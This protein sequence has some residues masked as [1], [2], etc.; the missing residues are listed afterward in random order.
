MPCLFACPPPKKKKKPTRHAASSAW[1]STS[2]T[3]LVH[4]RIAVDQCRADPSPNLSISLTVHPSISLTVGLPTRQPACLP[5]C[6]CLSIRPHLSHSEVGVAQRLAG[7]RIQEALCEVRQRGCRA[8]LL[9]RVV[10]TDDTRVSASC[11]ASS[12]S[13]HNSVHEPIQSL[14]LPEKALKLDADKLYAAY[15]KASSWTKP[16]PPTM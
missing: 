11:A 4:T 9:M 1:P 13:F 5:A 8:A 6:V 15:K 12:L 10:S 3:C 14:N 2:W 16:R 7:L